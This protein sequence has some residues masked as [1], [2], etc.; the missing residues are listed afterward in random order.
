M[1]PGSRIRARYYAAK[2]AKE[3]T[4]REDWV[5]IDTETT[6]LRNAEIVQIGVLSGS[7]EMLLDSLV[8]P[9]IPIPDKTS[10][11][12]GITDDQVRNAPTF[13]EIYPH[14]VD[15][16]A[17]KAVVIYNAHF[18]E[19]I[20]RH[21]CNLAHF[22]A[23]SFIELHCAMH[24][25][26]Q[27]VGDWSN[28]HG[29]Y[30]WPK[31]PGGDH[32][33]IG[34]CL[35]TLKII[36]MMANSFVP[37]SELVRETPGSQGSPI[38]LSEEKTT[39][40]ELQYSIGGVIQIYPNQDK[41]TTTINHKLELS[42]VEISKEFIKEQPDLDISSDSHQSRK[43]DFIQKNKLLKPEE[44]VRFEEQP[45][46]EELHHCRSDKSPKNINSQQIQSYV[47][48]RKLGLT[49]SQAAY[50]ADFSERT[51]QRIDSGN[52]RP[53]EERKRDWRT[54][55]DPLANVWECDL[56]PVLQQKPQLSAVKLLE[57]IQEKHPGKYDSSILRTLQRRVR[58]WRL[59]TGQLPPPKIEHE[60]IDSNTEYEHIEWMK[61]LSNGKIEYAEIE[62][63]FL[64][65]LEIEDLHFLLD[66]IPDEP[67]RYRNRALTIL[68]Y[69]K[70]IPIYLI[71]QFLMI[72]VRTVKR[73]VEKYKICGA[74]N[75]LDFSRKEIKKAQDP[76]FVN[77][78][79]EILHAPP[80]SYDI[81]RTSWTMKDLHRVMAE[82]GFRIAP[83]N[84]RQIIRDSGYK[85]RNAKKVLTSTDPN[86]RD[87][88]QKITQILS[89][90]G[91]KDKFFSIDEFGPF[92]V[93]IQG[94]RS[95]MPP[96]EVRTI[97]QWQKSKGK[98]IMTAALELSTNQV[99]HFYSEKKD[100][101]E[102]IKLLDILLEKYVDEDCIYLS[103]DAASWHASQALYEKVDEVNSP[104]YRKGSN[105]PTV[106]LA[107][108]PA[109]AQFLNIIESVFSGM[110]R[111]II[112]NSNYQSVEDCK[113]AIDRYFS[114][115]NQYFIEHP[116]RAGKKIWGE[117][118]VEVEFKESNNCKD[119]RWR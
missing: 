47:R 64:A 51:G 58:H 85:F 114:E 84:I 37:E 27:W 40:A 39:F 66:K 83:S 36:Q 112:H 41:Q 79:F 28:Y 97:P 81:N 3:L 89:N 62:L 109:G 117:E 98:L 14:F 101:E 52:Y 80:S 59:S 74:R 54:R 19:A 93:K 104:E 96:G 34:D 116:K 87:K 12:H 100:T 90:L 53:G 56:V 57:Y 50:I 55:K 88:L 82:A 70:G 13:P 23:P 18:D 31:L 20:F 77:K 45:V 107:P 105:F 99:T 106:K 108:L 48:A 11:I 60:H 26:A 115:R 69:L 78:V 1:R 29:N 91:P 61:R 43:N 94:G 103:W 6:G 16:I 22:E 9:T 118:L 92:S 24:W 63:L 44:D 75:L 21:C 4:M 38:R 68:F 15:L 102:M 30:R 35:A 7:G 33:A 113:N 32:T 71:A 65:Y 49:Q 72:K 67:L 5:I 42:S 73:Y 17:N 86:Y 110:A 10:L 76:K 25:Y 95:L 111:A 46:L 8:K 2:W 119:P